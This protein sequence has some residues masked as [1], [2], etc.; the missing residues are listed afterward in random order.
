MAIAETIGPQLYTIHGPRGVAA[1][2]FLRDHAITLSSH[3]VLL[4]A[5]HDEATDSWLECEPLPSSSTDRINQR[6]AFRF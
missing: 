3:D 5:E 2:R 6:S 1:A 4:I